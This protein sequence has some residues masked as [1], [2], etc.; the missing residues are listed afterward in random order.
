MIYSRDD[1][2]EALEQGILAIDPVPDNSMYSTSSVDL[3]LAS[4][5]TIFDQASDDSGVYVTAGVSDPEDIAAQYGTRREISSSGYLELKPGQFV[6][7]YTV[8]RVELPLH[9]AARVEG[10]SSMARFG[11]SIHQ[12]A[13]TIHAD[14][15]GNIRLEISNA[16]PFL[17]RLS[18][19]EPICQLIVEEVRT[20]TTERLRSR[21]Q[22]QHP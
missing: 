2:K 1:I 8:E 11:L 4:S 7:A 12:T 6:L 15:R 10:K 13:P 5:F 20:P 14:F 21:F 3:R 17:C 22:E 19:G 9:L 16:G 18:P